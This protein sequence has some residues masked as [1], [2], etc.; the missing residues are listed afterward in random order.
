MTFAILKVKLNNTDVL[1]IEVGLCCVPYEEVQS[2]LKNV[3]LSK[4]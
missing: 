1:K 3:S 2:P 4:M